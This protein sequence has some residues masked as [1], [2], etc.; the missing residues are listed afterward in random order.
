MELAELPCPRPGRGQLLIQT[1]ASL[2]SA[3]TERM[4]VEFSQANLLQKARQQPDKVKQVLD[5]MKTDGLMPTLE[6]VF[7]KLDEPLPL[8]YCNAGVVLEVGPGVHDIQPGDRVASNGP[9][10]EIACVPRNLCARIPE[11]VNDSHAAFTVMGSIAL[12]GVRL[13]QPTLGEKFVVFG[14]GLLGLLTTQLL[15]ASGCE[16]LA[17]DLSPE[18]LKLAEQ[19][20]ATTVNVGAG[21]DPI[22]AAEAWTNGTGADGVIITASAKTDAIMHQAASACRQR[23]RVILVGVVG[24][25]LR[26][27]DFFKK[28]ISF[29]VSCSY[30]PGRYDEKYEQAGQ[31]YPVGYVR[32]TEQ[33]NFDAVLG[34]ISSGGLQIEPLITDK[35][36]FSDAISAYEK[37]QN[38]PSA[39]GILLD[40]PQEADRSTIVRVSPATSTSPPGGGVV[41]GVI[42]AGGF[43]KGVLIP[44]IMKSSAQL[45]SVASKG[46]ASGQQ[47][48]RK[49]G[50]ADATTDHRTILDNPE[51]NAV[52][53][54]LGHHLH[55]RFVIEALE[56]G[57]HVFVEKPLAMNEEELVQIE[58]AYAACG[59]E[60]KLQLMVGFNRRFSPHTAKIRELLAGRSEPLC[61]N[62]T[63]NGG[64]IPAEHWIQDPER[65][66]GRIIGEG[67]HFIDLLANVAGSAIS[68]VSAVMVG[69]GVAVRDDKMAMVLR[70]EDG[71]LGTV[72][73]FSNGS[74][75]YPKETLEVFSDGR[76]LRMENFRVTRGYGFS[77]FK[78]FKTSR[79]DKGHNSEVAAFADTI[80]TGGKAL[81]PFAELA[82]STRASFAAVES[83][84]T[85]NSIVLK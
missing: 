66:G 30:G 26:R 35:I 63:V 38:D 32:W 27:D 61:M 46:G 64:A 33:R 79:Q 51:V 49:F 73:Y 37:V 52:F 4:L 69:E 76:V 43:A 55:A 7:R 16:V 80:K 25:N 31:D 83:A 29:Q 78:K 65:G 5:K 20:G 28:E 6:A 24:L 84:K 67:C 41:A 36:A 1:S 85:G 62:M 34:A 72:N 58:T 57:K 59:G 71:S 23:G 48:A 9:H 13:S 45:V 82:N 60:E 11:G 8:G 18:R 19:F 10:A 14:L 22:A 40:Y 75:S 21:G 15:R 54:L 44:A 3:G 50:V 77:G 39:L 47:A 2:I 12:Q 17:V 56:A 74:S 81:I 53:V 70:F 42:G 68:S